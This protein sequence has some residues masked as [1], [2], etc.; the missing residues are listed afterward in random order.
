MKW[1]LGLDSSTTICRVAL[2]HKD[3]I[4]M[5]E[6]ATVQGEHSAYIL[7]MIER[8]MLAQNIKG[9]QLDAIAFGRGPGGFTGL[10]LALSVAQGLAYGWDCPLVAVSSLAAMAYRLRLD[11]HATEAILPIWV[12]QD[13]RMGQ[14]YAGFY[15]LENGVLQSIVSDD[16]YDPEALV[17]PTGFDQW[18]VVG[19][20]Y[21][22][23]RSHW[24]ALSSTCHH[25]ADSDHPY[26][27]DVAL[28][29]ASGQGKTVPV[30]QAEPYYC[31]GEVH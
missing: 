3:E 14:V 16:L 19:S 26:A 29:A 9:K 30:D 21:G 25:Q 31:R 4:V 1:V 5:E 20:G 27:S 18:W 6:S 24:D 17:L 28:L 12:V 23:Y 11:G 22:V 2:C 13:A 15:T 10:R 7:P 8:M